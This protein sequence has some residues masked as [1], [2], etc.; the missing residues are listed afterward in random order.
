MGR[1]LKEKKVYRSLLWYVGTEKKNTFWEPSRPANIQAGPP[2]MNALIRTFLWSRSSTALCVT[3]ILW[4]SGTH[5]HLH[6]GEMFPVHRPICSR[7]ARI[8]FQTW[9]KGNNSDDL[10]LV[11]LGCNS[12]PLI[13]TLKAMGTTGL[14]VSVFSFHLLLVWTKA[15]LQVKQSVFS[16]FFFPC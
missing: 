6:R 5:T 2:K 8:H 7:Q 1:L 16:L 15:S 10:S 12:M 3:F 4:H 13:T 14:R 11:L 9:H